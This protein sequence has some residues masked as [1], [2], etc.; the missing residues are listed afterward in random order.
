MSFQVLVL[1]HL[2]FSAY[3]VPQVFILLLISMP[4]GWSKMT[5]MT[6]AFGV[7]LVADLFVGTPGIHTSAC[8]WL[9]LIRIGILNTQD[10]KQ[11]VANKLTYDVNAVGFTPF[12]YTTAI[13]VLFYH[14]Y[15]FWLQ[16]IGAL[17]WSNYLLTAF[18]SS[19]L[20]LT[21]IGVIQYLSFQRK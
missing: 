8:L 1:N 20:S 15:I 18:I 6:A 3:V 13:L 14:L 2:D 19:I 7:G 11:Q 4:L 16:N 21:I 5:Q 17:H 9:V 12:L 10:I